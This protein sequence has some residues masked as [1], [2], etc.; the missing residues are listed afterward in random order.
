VVS[1][2]WGESLEARGAQPPAMICPECRRSSL[3]LRI[4]ALDHYACCPAAECGY[5][6]GPIPTALGWDVAFA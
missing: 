6:S 4:V 5:Y 1:E 3:V 2:V